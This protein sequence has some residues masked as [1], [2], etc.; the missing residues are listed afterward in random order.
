MLPKPA[1]VVVSAQHVPISLS[2]SSA[3]MPAITEIAK[4]R[5]VD[6]P[7]LGDHVV[8]APPRADCW[9]AMF[10]S[11]SRLPDS[12]AR[13]ACPY[14]ALAGP[15]QPARCWWR[16]GSTSMRTQW[17]SGR[18]WPKASSTPGFAD[19]PRG[20]RAE[21]FHAVRDRIELLSSEVGRR[22]IAGATE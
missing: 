5:S 17:P 3:G 9:V 20:R 4:A 21:Q 11:D 6:G 7:H 1:I 14:F 18:R 10:V 16:P 22:S 19:A 8:N 2:M 13:G 12:L 15:H